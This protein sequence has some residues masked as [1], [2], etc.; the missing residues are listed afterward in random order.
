MDLLGPVV[1]HGNQPSG[2]VMGGSVLDSSG[3]ND[4]AIRVVKIDPNGCS[5]E[6]RTDGR[7]HGGQALDDVVAEIDKDLTAVHKNI[8]LTLGN[9]T[10]AKLD[11][12][13]GQGCVVYSLL[14]MRLINE[15]RWGVCWLA[16]RRMRF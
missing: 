2:M 9:G 14:V 8:G 10:A 7:W 16:L 3:L 1:G 6:Q 5:E 12:D 11:G 13:V 15:G 4:G